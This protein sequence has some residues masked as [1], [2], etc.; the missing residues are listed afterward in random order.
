MSTTNDGGN[1]F[2][3]DPFA[4][5]GPGTEANA[6]AISRGMSLR[7]Y[8]AAKALPAVWSAMDDDM[9]C[10]PAVKRTAQLAYMLADAMLIARTA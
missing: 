2:P 6:T 4:A 7:D 9:E 1:A 3:A 5:K 8:F 10:E